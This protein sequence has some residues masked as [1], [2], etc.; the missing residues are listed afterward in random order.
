MSNYRE[1]N[2]SFR[3][4][5]MAIES[6]SRYVVAYKQKTKSAPETLLNIKKLVR[7]FSTIQFFM[8]D[9]GTEF[10]N[11]LLKQFLK[12]KKFTCTFR[13]MKK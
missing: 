13:T 7:K 11:K 5:L 2:R 10:T 6:F 1:S 12:E 8:T 3:Y 9:R 4:V